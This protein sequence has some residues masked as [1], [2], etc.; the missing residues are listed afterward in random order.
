[1]NDEDVIRRMHDI[2]RFGTVVRQ[3][4]DPRNA[5]DAGMWRWQVT[6]RQAAGLMLTIY[7]LMGARRR[8]RIR[9]VMKAWLAYPQ[10]RKRA[11]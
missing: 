1:M 3:R 7:P 9:S 5:R 8:E 2:L 4:P 6:G 10:I 11:S